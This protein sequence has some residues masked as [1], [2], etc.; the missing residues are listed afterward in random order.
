M[1]LTDLVTLKSTLTCINCILHLYSCSLTHIYISHILIDI[2][3]A[4]RKWP[5][6]LSCVLN[7]NNQSKWTPTITLS[8]IWPILRC[9]LT[10]ALVSSV[11][12][13]ASGLPLPAPP[14]LSVPGDISAWLPLS[15]IPLQWLPGEA[16]GW[17]LFMKLLPPQ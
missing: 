15:A 12:A 5:L 17:A 13:K 8:L 6:P 14:P 10:F 3:T 7:E 11:W 2:S 4:I 16:D 1:P 9:W